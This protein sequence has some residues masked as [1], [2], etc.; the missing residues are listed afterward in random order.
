MLEQFDL[1]LQ[2]GLQGCLLP[3]DEHRQWTTSSDTTLSPR[4]TT[5]R[6]DMRDN[7]SIRS[8][9]PSPTPEARQLMEQL[10]DSNSTHPLSSQSSPHRA[11]LD[12][13]SAEHPFDYIA[14]PFFDNTTPLIS[15]ISSSVPL[16]A[17]CSGL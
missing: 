1:A 6:P 16:C 14:T 13:F 5:N 11:L 7:R 12:R 9:T 15:C 3:L 4:Q 2:N 8:L 17:I 10:S